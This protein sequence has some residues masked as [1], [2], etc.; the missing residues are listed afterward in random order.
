MTGDPLALPNPRTVAYIQVEPLVMLVPVR[1]IYTGPTQLD[2]FWSTL[3]THADRGG[4]PITS[5]HLQKHLQPDDISN[6]W[7]D[8]IG[9]STDSLA[10]TIIVTTGVGI[11]AVVPGENYAFRVRAKNIYGWGPFSPVLDIHAAHEPAKPL[12]PTTSIDAATGG[13]KIEW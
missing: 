9:L 5:Y 13:L 2:V 10:N 6:P 3:T 4:S 8:V 7:E 12:P 1:M 11:A